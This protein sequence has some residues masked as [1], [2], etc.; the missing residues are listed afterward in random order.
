MLPIVNDNVVP[1]LS[2]VVLDAF[3]HPDLLYADRALLTGIHPPADREQVPHL[4]GL[5]SAAIPTSFALGGSAEGVCFRRVAWG[6]GVKVMYQHLL[7][8]VRSLSAALLREITVMAFN[9]A[10]P[11]PIMSFGNSSYAHSTVDAAVGTVSASKR[12]LQMAK[13][14]KRKGQ[15]IQQRANDDS[16]EGLDPSARGTPANQR[17]IN[18][19]S[20]IA[21]SNLNTSTTAMSHQQARR[22][23]NVVIYTRGSSGV[24]RTIQGEELLRD[25]LLALGARA[26]ICCDFRKVSLSDQL[27][28]AVHADAIIGLH[29][30]GLINNLFAPTGTITVEL[31]TIYGYG[32]T[33][34]AVSSDARQGSF[35]EINIKD[36]H[37]WGK[38]G[39]S[40]NKPID[41]PLMSRITDALFTVLG[42]TESSQLALAAAEQRG[43]GVPVPHTPTM[44]DQQKLLH[45]AQLELNTLI[46]K[47]LQRDLFVPLQSTPSVPRPRGDLTMYSYPNTAFE[48]AMTALAAANQ[49]HYSSANNHSAPTASLSSE[50]S[51]Q[52][53]FLFHP[54][55]PQISDVHAQ[56]ARLTVSAYWEHLHVTMKDVHERYCVACTLPVHSNAVNT[57]TNRNNDNGNTGSMKALPVTSDA[58]SSSTSTN[59]L[60][61]KFKL[62]ES[63]KSPRNQQQQH[64]HKQLMDGLLKGNL[65]GQ[66]KNHHN[67]HNQHRKHLQERQQPV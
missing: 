67:Q 15:K 63:P 6:G 52:L 27:G 57:G 47:N 8:A 42:Y 64:Q 21:K 29:G 35:V 62:L 34:F 45:T 16:T 22:P 31:K 48:A 53:D 44:Q 9:P 60:L 1:L 32:L 2:L 40:R 5:L 49:S 61:E 28:Y 38:P 11:Y 30:A 37:I 43:V 7:G 24:G 66:Q 46:N 58:T 65:M 56:C 54:L 55:G 19:L 39:Q 13:G 14:T 12:S 25:R 51:S 59:A 4:A 23:M 18:T 10:D 26:A 36:Y 17:K 50:T 33:L 41:E 20:V 3:H